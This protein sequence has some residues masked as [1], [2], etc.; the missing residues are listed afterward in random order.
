MIA[1]LC[2]LTLMASCAADAALDPT[3]APY[4]YTFHERAE[5]RPCGPRAGFSGAATEVCDKVAR[6]TETEV[7][8]EDGSRLVMEDYTDSKG[9]RCGVL[10]VSTETCSAKY[11]VVATPN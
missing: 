2:L 7:V 11:G 6:Q 8:C 4:A 9:G 3:D 5:D 10:Y 1:R